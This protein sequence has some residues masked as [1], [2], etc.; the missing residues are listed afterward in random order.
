M[1]ATATAHSA[2]FESMSPPDG[3]TITDSTPSASVTFSA[4]VTIQN[5]RIALPD[6]RT[7]EP[8]SRTRGAVTDF[9]LPRPITPGTATITWQVAQPDGHVVTYTKTYVFDESALDE[10]VGLWRDLIADAL[11][12]MRSAL[13][14]WR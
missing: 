13:A 4:P 3:A 9:A 10:R 7:V 8:V 5:L 12:A 2:L 6:G 11:V 14:A 1:T